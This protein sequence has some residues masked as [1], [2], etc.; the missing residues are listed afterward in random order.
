[1]AT[2]AMPA[3]RSF[4]WV[5]GSSETSE[6]SQTLPGIA[7]CRCAPRTT[8]ATDRIGRAKSLPDDGSSRAADRVWQLPRLWRTCRTD[9]ALTSARSS[10]KAR[11]MFSREPMDF[12]QCSANPID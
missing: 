5:S 4:D 1:M 8:P 3:S 7:L 6:A 2:S 9:F 11:S 12:C 10:S